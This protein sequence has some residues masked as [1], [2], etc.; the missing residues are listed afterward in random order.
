MNALL[1]ITGR[2]FSYFRQNFLLI[3]ITVR[4]GVP[5]FFISKNST[6]RLLSKFSFLPYDSCQV[7]LRRV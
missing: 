3:F 7:F 2:L 6:F 5:F 1:N 4:D